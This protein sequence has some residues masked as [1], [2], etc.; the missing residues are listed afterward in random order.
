M[1]SE[2]KESFQVSRGL[3]KLF[4]L[5]RQIEKG[6]LETGDR[7]LQALPGCAA[8][9]NPAGWKC[10]QQAAQNQSSE[11][12]ALRGFLLQDGSIEAWF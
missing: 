9:G 3:L 6:W 8:G 10:G 1:W 2:G 12:I 7:W 11:S 4:I 5:L